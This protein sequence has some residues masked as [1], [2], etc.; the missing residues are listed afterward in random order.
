VDALACPD[1][2]AE[3]RYAY[4][5]AAAADGDWRAAADMFEQT[6]ER[7]PDWAPAW[8]ALGEAREKLGDVAGAVAAYSS[9]LRAD[10]LDRQGAGPLLARLENRTVAALPPAYVARLFD[11]YAPR[12]D[13]HL[14][15]TLG[16]RGPELIV[17]A[18]DRAAPGRR[19]GEALDLGCGSGLAGRALRDRVERLVGVDLSA[20]MIAQAQ[21]AGV[22][23]ELQVGDLLAFLLGRPERQADLAVAADALVYVGDLRPVFS[24]ASAA[25]ASGGLFVFTVESGEATFALGPAL[26]FRHSD[27][28]VREAAAAAG[29]AI[30]HLAAVATRREAGAEAPGRVVALANPSRS[31]PSRSKP[32]RWQGS[33]P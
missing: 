18:L 22:Y 3:R 25:L 31:K 14:T 26:R 10:P 4:A 8:A 6:L 24:A 5:R 20:G 11:D 17:S 12:F 1:P 7:A 32:S 27:A 19:F 21:A 30:V 13:R 15:Q 29:L 33:P 9:A 28:H 2:L 16:Y 23:D